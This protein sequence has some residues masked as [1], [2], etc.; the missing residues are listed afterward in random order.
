MTLTLIAFCNAAGHEYGGGGGYGRGEYGGGV[1]AGG[2][3]GGRAVSG[4]GFSWIFDSAVQSSSSDTSITKSLFYILL[5]S[6]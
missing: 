4:G 2:F 3:V 5:H 1:R 6:G